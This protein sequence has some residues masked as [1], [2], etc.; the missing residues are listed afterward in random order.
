MAALTTGGL[1]S[2]TYATKVEPTWFETVEIDLALPRLPEVFHGYRIVQISDFHMEWTGQERLFDIVGRVNGLTPDL[3]VMTGDYVT[4]TYSRAVEDLVPPLR[5][6]RAGDGVVGV[7]GNHDYWGHHGPAIIR[8]VLAESNSIE[9]SNKVHTI[10]RDGQALHI[11]GADSVREGQDRLSRVVQNLP[12]RGCSILIVHEP[13]FA[14][15]AARTGRFDLQLSGH[16]HGGQVV[17]PFVG[18]PHLPP[19]GRKYH[20]GL[21]KVGS[22]LEYT[23]RGLGM[24]GLPVRFCCRPEITVFTLHAGNGSGHRI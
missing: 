6:L 12:N 8:R 13:D 1:G 5:A 11:A 14:D 21:Y 24:V 20:T 18:P 17:V 16:S 19:M 23:N 7:L 4:R 3:V 15:K 9:L 10:E 22:M 2:L